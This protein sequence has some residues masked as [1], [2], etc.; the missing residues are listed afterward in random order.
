M[1]RR[2]LGVIGENLACDWLR[3]RGFDIIE[4]N[5]HCRAGEIDII[6]R[7][8]RRDISEVQSQAAFCNVPPSGCC[9]IEVKMRTSL[10][11]GSGLESLNQTKLMHLRSA[12]IWWLQQNGLPHEVFGGLFLL[13]LDMVEAGCDCS[14]SVWCQVLKSDFVVNVVEIGV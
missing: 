7:R 1:D 10:N 3:Q 4:R 14:N 12:A 2:K 5:F 11:F 13:S 8:S 6:C 9:F